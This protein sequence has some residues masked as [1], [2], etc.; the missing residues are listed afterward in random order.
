MPFYIYSSHCITLS[1][2]L[3]QQAD[4]LPFRCDVSFWSIAQKR[5]E[6][7]L[8]NAEQSRNFHFQSM[9]TLQA[10][11]WSLGNGELAFAE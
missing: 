1:D 5:T 3:G 7:A 6:D 9:Q 8:E 11:D 2:R 10:G 4:V